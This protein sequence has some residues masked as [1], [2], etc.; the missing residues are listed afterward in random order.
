VLSAL[1]GLRLLE[2]SLD[3]V[4]SLDPA[5]VLLLPNDI[6]E[7]AAAPLT[8]H[9]AGVTSHMDIHKSLKALLRY[10]R[11]AEVG[12]VAARAGGWEEDPVLAQCFALQ[13][14]HNVVVFQVRFRTRPYSHALAVAHSCT[15]ALVH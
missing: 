2:Q 9:L 13:E 3:L 4:T 7:A 11:H 1:R 8:S 5:A 15:R 6:A 10:P 14:A 12:R